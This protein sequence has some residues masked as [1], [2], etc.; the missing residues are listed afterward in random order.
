MVVKREKICVTH[1]C[2]KGETTARQKNMGNCFTQFSHQIVLHVALY[3]LVYIINIMYIRIT[4]VVNDFLQV[5]FAF[6]ITKGI[7]FFICHSL[8]EVI[9][10]VFR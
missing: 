4:K 5:I 7:H 2:Y 6:T 9:V 8:I 3:I 10:L 1:G